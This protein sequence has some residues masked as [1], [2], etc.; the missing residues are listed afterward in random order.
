MHTVNDTYLV[1]TVS[2]PRRS[3]TKTERPLTNITKKVCHLTYS[4]WS[5]HVLIHVSTLLCIFLTAEEMGCFNQD[6][7]GSNWKYITFYSFQED[8][9]CMSVCMQVCVCVFWD[10][11]RDREGYLREK[12]TKGQ[13][14]MRKLRKYSIVPHFHLLFILL[15][16]SGKY[17]DYSFINI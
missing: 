8:E 9:M 17:S 3:K 1:L 6:P 10:K 2:T 4:S 15:S 5:R 16:Y 13:H 12:E 11:W 7:N 14:K